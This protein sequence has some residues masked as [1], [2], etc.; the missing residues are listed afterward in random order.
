M[1]RVALYRSKKKQLTR[2]QRH[3]LPPEERRPVGRPPG[4]HT[5]HRTPQERREYLVERYGDP[6]EYMLMVMANE[7]NKVPRRDHMAIQ[8]APYV[9]PKMTT[10]EMTGDAEKPVVV[11]ED[12]R[13]LS[14]AELV[15]RFAETVKR[16]KTK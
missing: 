6:V 14:D 9:S 10:M 7:R 8:A 12:L 1:A 2:K 15:K 4:I 13:K 3:A 16:G 5:K 11:K